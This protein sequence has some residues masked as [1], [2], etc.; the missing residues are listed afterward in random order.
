MSYDGSLLS[1]RA[2]RCLWN[3]LGER[4]L[5]DL[6]QQWAS[7]RVEIAAISLEWQMSWEVVGRGKM[8][9]Y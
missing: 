9:V 3:I 4:M 8:I 6:G 1:G 5:G 2:D 7:E